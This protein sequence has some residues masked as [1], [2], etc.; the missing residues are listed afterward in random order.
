MKVIVT[1]S[2]G[3]VGEGVLL[4]CLEDPRIE[5][6]LSVSRRSTGL[7]HPKLEEYLVPDFMGLQ[8]GDEHLQG[9]DAV[10]FCAGISS[11]GMPM[12]K[13]KVIS[14]DI[15]LHFAEVTG[16]K[17]TMS[18]SYVS[19]YGTSDKNPQEWAKIK[20]STEKELAAMPFKSVLWYRPCF[21]LPHPD[22]R[23]RRSFQIA[24]RIIY[25][26]ARLFGMANTIRQVASSMIS[27]SADPAV[28]GAMPVGVKEISR[29]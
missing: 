22:Q 21:M 9:Y 5:K 1:G 12:D 6:V 8:P 28:R 4:S 10:F 23:F 19:G 2:T 17:E 13:Y 25:P 14:H 29:F 16:P 24:T 26:F 7:S 3:Y 11:V 27:L 20:S 18:F 15:P